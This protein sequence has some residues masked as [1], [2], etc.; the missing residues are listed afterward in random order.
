MDLLALQ[1][2]AL[3]GTEELSSG[4]LGALIALGILVFLLLLVLLIAVYVYMS[5]AF[6]GIA[7]KAKYKSPAIAWIPIVGPAIILS[8]SAEMHWWP[9]LLLIGAII[10]V[11]GLLFGIAFTVFFTIWTWK[12]FEKIK[13]P[14]WWAILCLITPLNLIFWGIAAWSK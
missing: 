4:T 7:R 2:A 11:V 10:P 3:Y 8:S 9:I 14:G 12:T 6:A 13:K 1:D 5:L